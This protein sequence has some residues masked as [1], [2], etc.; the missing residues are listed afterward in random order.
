MLKQPSGSNIEVKNLNAPDPS[1][2]M[3]RYHL[4]ILVGL[5]ETYKP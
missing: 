1:D 5:V 2:K 3:D 4:E